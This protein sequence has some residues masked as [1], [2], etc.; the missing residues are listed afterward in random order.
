LGA[1]EVTD[2]RWLEYYNA[3]KHR[4]GWSGL[5]ITTRL[6]RFNRSMNKLY[7]PTRPLLHIGTNIKVEMWKY[8]GRN[9]FVLRWRYLLHARKRWKIANSFSPGHYR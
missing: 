4:K 1:D 5:M 7:I 9:S 3:L 6:V 8:S 2:D